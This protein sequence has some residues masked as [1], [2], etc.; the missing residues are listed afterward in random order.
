MKYLIIQLMLIMLM[1]PAL[2]GCVTEVDPETGQE[3]TRL[4]PEVAQRVGKVS[5]AVPAVRQG[6]DV[7]SI[8]WPS[9]AAVLGVIGGAVGAAKKASDKYKPKLTEAQLRQLQYHNASSAVV[10]AIEEFKQTNSKDWQSLKK[11]LTKYI[12]PEAE[13]VI[14][15]IRGLPAKA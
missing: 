2:S 5:E 13:N 8:I 1:V 3:L 15:A 7:A 12:G 6:L 11:K 14:R 4:D 10:K 9:A